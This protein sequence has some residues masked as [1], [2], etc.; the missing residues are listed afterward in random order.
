MGRHE[1][2]SAAYALL[3]PALPTNPKK[4]GAP[5]S[6][7]RPIL[8]GIFWQLATGCSWHDISEQY[9][10]WQTIYDRYRARTKS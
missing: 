10:V 5:W 6:A 8:N 7:H 3:E 1:L 9:G 4:V 2:R